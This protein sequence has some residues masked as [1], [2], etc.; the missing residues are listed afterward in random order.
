M[1]PLDKINEYLESSYRNEGNIPTNVLLFLCASLITENNKLKAQ[2]KEIAD[3]VHAI[4]KKIDVLIH[5][6]KHFNK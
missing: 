3:G 5:R 6:A 4:E 1:T 2:A